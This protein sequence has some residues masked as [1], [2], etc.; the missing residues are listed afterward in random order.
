MGYI[1][2][3]HIK[4]ETRESLT[5]ANAFCQFLNFND[6]LS[7]GRKN[8]IC[9]Q[10]SAYVGKGM[11]DRKSTRTCA[12]AGA[13]KKESGKFMKEFETFK[14]DKLLESTKKALK[15]KLDGEKCKNKEQVN[16]WKNS[17]DRK[18]E[19]FFDFIKA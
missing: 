15:S 2:E 17:T 10:Y 1:C 5:V 18:L 14:V 16:G 3:K 13:F 11:R 4:R 9:R 12:S 7:A 19:L 6:D 8:K